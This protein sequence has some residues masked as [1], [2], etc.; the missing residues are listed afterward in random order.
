M[1]KRIISQARG[2]GSLS[3]QARKQAFVYRVGYPAKTGEAIVRAIIHSPAHSAPL[4][5][6]FAG[7]EKFYNLAFEG[8]VEG[9]K[10]MIGSTIA[11]KGN[12]LMLKDIVP[13]TRVYNI[14]RNPGDGGKMMRVAGT[15]ALVSKKYEHDKV[16]VL[17]PSK[18]EIIL[19]W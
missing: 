16:G 12:I 4:I 14:E 2:K 15:S 17:T 13:G 1:G 8:A 10:I 18:K 5:K 3:Y 11:Q 9:Q 7:D 6:A 19:K